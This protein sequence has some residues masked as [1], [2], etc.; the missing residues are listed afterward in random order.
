MLATVTS[1]ASKEATAFNTAVQQ[2]SSSLAS[3]VKEL[4]RA[5]EALSTIQQLYHLAE[6]SVFY[7]NPESPEELAAQPDLAT[8]LTKFCFDILAAPR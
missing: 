5:A 4:P 2:A 7:V 6:P 1:Q 8:G 3:A